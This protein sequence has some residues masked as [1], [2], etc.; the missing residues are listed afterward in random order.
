MG[1]VQNGTHTYVLCFTL[2]TNHSLHA[3]MFMTHK[4]KNISGEMLVNPKSLQWVMLFK[5][6][7]LHLLCF[8]CNYVYYNNNSCRLLLPQPSSPLVEFLPTRENIYLKGLG[9]GS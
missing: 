8:I 4:V 9:L 7:H 5:I 2:P 6:G 3:F 1:M